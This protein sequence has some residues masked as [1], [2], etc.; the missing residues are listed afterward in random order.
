MME[1]MTYPEQTG[2]LINRFLAISSILI[3]TC[4]LANYDLNRKSQSQYIR[5]IK[6]ADDNCKINFKYQAKSLSKTC[7]LLVIHNHNID[8]I[9]NASTCIRK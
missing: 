1:I 9:K 2:T 7:K 4:I 3:S 5:C 8:Q 6:N